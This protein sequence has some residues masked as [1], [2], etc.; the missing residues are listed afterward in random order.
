MMGEGGGLRMK[1]FTWAAVCLG[2]AA[3]AVALAHTP[4]AGLI[5]KLTGLFG[6]YA[7]AS[8]VPGVVIYFSCRTYLKKVEVSNA[9]A[10]EARH[11]AEQARAHVEELSRQMAEQERIRRALQESEERFRTAFDHAAV[12]LALVSP[13]GRWLQVNRSLCELLG[14]SETELLGSDFQSV[15]HA[16]SLPAALGQIDRLLRGESPTCQLEVRFVHRS[17]QAVWSSLSV[18][19][20]NI[21]SQVC[22][23]LNF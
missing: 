18:L 3:C 10:E 17:C 11:A 15:T 19:L 22:P 9:Q 13:E 20:V 14:H 16:E 5:T 4:A 6:F 7:V 23:H 8:A 12:G 1:I 2:A 21:S